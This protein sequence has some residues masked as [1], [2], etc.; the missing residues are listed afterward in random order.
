M[1]MAVAVL[2][3]EPRMKLPPLAPKAV[4]AIPNTRASINA[5]PIMNTVAFPAH[6]ILVS[7]PLNILCSL[8]LMLSCSMMGRSAKSKRPVAA[9]VAAVT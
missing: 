5:K 2:F 3:R 7:A 4:E 6:S 8:S 9:Y 1:V